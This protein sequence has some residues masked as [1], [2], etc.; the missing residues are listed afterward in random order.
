MR[1][2]LFL[3]ALGAVLVALTFSFPFWFPVLQPEQSDA[4]QEVF[5][6]LSAD[7]Q[8]LF[9]MLPPDQQAAYREVAASDQSRAVAMIEAALSPGF[10]A[11]TEEADIPAMAGAETV[12]TGEFTRIDSIRWA[13]GTITVYQQVDES[14][15]L[16]FENFSAANG[17][18][19]RVALTINRPEA[20]Q[21]ESEADAFDPIEDIRTNGL[22]LGTLLGTTG[23][24]NYAIPPEIDIS[25]Y[26]NVVIYSPTIAMIYSVA[27]LTT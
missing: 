13:Q 10:P 21:D 4:P 14:K 2:R 12:A 15:I 5:P 25:Q 26:D 7:M 23:S 18:G 20:A 3:I 8:S 22:D 27:P 16:R 1:F 24:Q 17:P 6:G 11:S 19:L 9:Q